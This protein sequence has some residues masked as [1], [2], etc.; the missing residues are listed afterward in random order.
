VVSSSAAL[1]HALYF[2]SF[3]FGGVAFAVGFGLVAAGVSVTS[4]FR[5]LLPAWVVV[6]GMVIALAGEL[7]SLS[8]VWYPAS[9]LLP[10]TRFGGFI[11]LIAVAVW[12]PKTQATNAIEGRS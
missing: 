5:H 11:W 1:V 12:L 8:L 3:L 7:S 9:F 10:L 2:L 4:H 6:L